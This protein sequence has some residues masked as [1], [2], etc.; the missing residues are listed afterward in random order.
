MTKK[1]SVYFI[2]F[3]A[4]LLGAFVIQDYI[5]VH[6]N[7]YLSFSLLHIYIFHFVASLL[8]TVGILLLSKS[9]KWLPQLGFLY[10]FAFITKFLFFAAAFKQ[11]LFK[12]ESLTKT[13][14]LNLL[15][16]LFLFLILEVFFITKILNKK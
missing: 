1:I 11:H 3:L 7:S 5:L 6:L 13:E 9:N 4:L 16:P 2:S 15:I 14:S 10:I 12:N 8:I